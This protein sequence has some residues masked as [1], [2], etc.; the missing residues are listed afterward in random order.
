MLFFFISIGMRGQNKVHQEIEKP[1]YECDSMNVKEENERMN[2]HENERTENKS[3]LE[4]SKSAGEEVR[5]RK[6]ERIRK[7]EEKGKQPN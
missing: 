5:K 4:G 3:V 6:E 7:M 2:A 1:K